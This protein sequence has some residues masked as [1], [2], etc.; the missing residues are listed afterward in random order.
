ML[1]RWGS[2][3]ARSAG[4]PEG[5]TAESF[6]VVGF[7]LETGVLGGGVRVEARSPGRDLVNGINVL[8]AFDKADQIDH[9]S[10]P[11]N[12]ESVGTTRGAVL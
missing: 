9:D 6:R 8:H 12:A 11:W 10:A 1:A 5:A 4:L 7:A 3:T 2:A